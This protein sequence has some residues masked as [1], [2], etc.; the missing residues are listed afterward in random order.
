M[1]VAFGLLGGCS[2]SSLDDG[3]EIGDEAPVVPVTSLKVMSFN[4]WVGGSNVTN[5]EAKVRSAIEEAGAD[6]VAMQESN[7]LAA[8]LAA[9][10]GW[11]SVQPA[12]SVAVLSRYPITE[13]LGVA[14]HEAGVGVRVQL[15]ADPPQDVI[16]WS[17]HLTPFPYA[18]YDAC[19][20][21]MSTT[22]I[23]ARQVVTQLPE[24]EDILAQMEAYIADA[25][26]IPVFLIGDMNTAS[27]LDWTTDMA[28]LHCGY[29]LNFPVT[30]AIEQAGL[31]DAYRSLHPDP[32][33]SP[34]HTW[35]PIYESFV[36]A[37][38]KPEPQDRIDMIHYAGAGVTLESASVLVVGTPAQYPDHRANE[39]PSD[40]AAVVVSVSLLPGGGVVATPP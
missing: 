18:P 21:A 23:L 34:G 11:Y 15:A 32:R 7:G 16:V 31:I 35:S 28:D 22:E 14:L 10:L 33:E 26:D 6:I 27:H 25:D 29:A 9:Q 4:V 2:G 5:G 40:H 13:T 37:D 1:A 38:S 20:Q 17:V 19:L 39:W 3:A 36:Y 12:S 30:A 24:A 8:R